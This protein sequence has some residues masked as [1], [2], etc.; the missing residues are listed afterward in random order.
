MTASGRTP[1]PASRWRNVVWPLSISPPAGPAD[2][3]AERAAVRPDLQRRDLQLPRSPPRASSR[4]ERAPAGWRGHSDTE[5]LL[6][7]VRRLGLTAALDRWPA[8]SRSRCGTARERVLHLARDRLGEKPLYYGWVGDTLLFGSELKALR[9]HP[10]WRRRRSTATRSRSFLRHNYVPA[11]YSI[12]R[13]RRKL[14]AGALA[15]DHRRGD[16]GGAR[17][18]CAYWTGREA[19]RARPSSIRSTR[20]SREAVDELDD[21]AARARCGRQMVADVPLGAFLSGGIDS[22][23]IVALMQ[24]QSRAAGADLHDRLRRARAINEAAH[25]KAVAAAPRH[26]PH[27]ALRHAAS[28]RW[29]SSPRC[30]TIYDEPFAD[31]SQIPTFLVATARARARD[32]ERCPATAATSCS[33]A[34]TATSRRAADLDR[35]SAPSG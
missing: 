7:A 23:T 4:R 27:R 29:R 21:A 17:G 25:A 6:A 34:T 12:Y 13:G 32:R 1:R 35:S 33:A 18:R 14:L 11:P 3:V 30:P 31:S 15:H 8:C 9:A 19:A 22:S 26:R 10:A 16:A 20:R 2:G 5:I 24:A 28:R